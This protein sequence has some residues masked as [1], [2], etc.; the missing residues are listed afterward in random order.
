MEP[1]LDGLQLVGFLLV[2]VAI[3]AVLVAVDIVLA[4]FL[5]MT[6]RKIVIV[7]GS[8]RSQEAEVPAETDHEDARLLD[9]SKARKEVS[10]M[11]MMK[12]G[13][14]LLV[15]TLMT[16]CAGLTDEQQRALSGG[17]A[18]AAGG[19]LFGAI[20]GGSATI[21]AAVGGPVGIAAGLLYHEHERNKTKSKN[22]QSNGQSKDKQSEVR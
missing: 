18:G 5:Y 10:K 13:S 14:V 19:A 1:L 22:G 6:D 17:A 3:L 8:G 9:R 4:V 16:G 2:S 20:A 15:L 12:I 11:R 21:G 7:Q